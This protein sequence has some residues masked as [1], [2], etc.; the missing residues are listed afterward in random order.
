MVIRSFPAI[1]LLS[2]TLIW[3]GPAC[4]CSDAWY[5]WSA[6][7]PTVFLPDDEAAHCYA[8]EWWYY[9]GLLIAHDERA[10]GFEAVIFHT[11][12][13][14][15]VATPAGLPI[16][17]PI[18]MH[19]AH[20]AITDV[21]DQTFAYDQTRTIRSQPTVSEGFHL[22]TPVL[23][24]HGSEGHDHI[25]GRMSD[26]SYGLDLALAAGDAPLLHGEAGYVRYG[27]VGDSFYY[28][29]P[30]MTASGFIRHGN[31]LAAVSGEV[32]FDRQWGDDVR[33]PFLKW[34]WF[35]IRL[36]DGTIV[37]LYRF[38]DSDAFVDHGTLRKADGRDSTLEPED[39]TITNI[40]F[41][42]SPIS[43]ATY[44]VR[45]EIEIA[46]ANLAV[47]VNR[48]LDAQEL[49]TRST[50]LNVYWEGLC[51]VTGTREGVPVSGHAY[52]E[53]ANLNLP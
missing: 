34:I 6:E 53:M 48:A 13:G 1:V 46:P 4:V 50:T 24:L 14:V 5:E 31:D 49:D 42:T 25:S 28:S 33:N 27:A 19:V 30:R 36:D 23:T 9:T 45:W 41:W 29:R 51:W 44:P 2:S 12:P 52:V 20:F 38:L 21:A 3:I 11:A 15:F 26:G 10:Y 16:A 8:V 37:M 43:G 17:L 7:S 40:A 47:D 18:D 22:I 32:W 39:F 35:S